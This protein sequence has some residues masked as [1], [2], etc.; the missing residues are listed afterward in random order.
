MHWKVAIVYDHGDKRP[1]FHGVTCDISLTGVSILTEHNIFTEE[2]VTLL[3]AL[4]PRH[5]GQPKKVIEIRSAM[6]YTVHS[7]GHDMFRIGLSFLHFRDDGRKLLETALGE[8]IIAKSE[9]RQ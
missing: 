8:R 5:H 6:V 2:Q 9:L 7:A 3:L 1:T 4:P